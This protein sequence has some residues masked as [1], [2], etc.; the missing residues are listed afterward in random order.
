VLDV[1]NLFSSACARGSSA[2]ADLRRFPL[3][4][5]EYVHI[6]GGEFRDG[7]YVDTHGHDLV[8]P[9]VDLLGELL[10][11]FPGELPG[12]LL[13]RDTDIT[14]AGV[15]SEYDRLVAAVSR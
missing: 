4:A 7:L 1:A 8:E 10:A 15:R 2:A 6:A 13:E 12:V 14:V 11:L 5:V 3:E 9:V